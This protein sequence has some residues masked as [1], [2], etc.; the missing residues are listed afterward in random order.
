M[1][2]MSLDGK[3]IKRVHVGDMTEITED[4]TLI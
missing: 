2:A 4:G 3:K 1:E